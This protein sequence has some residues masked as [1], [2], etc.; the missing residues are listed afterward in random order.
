MNR[1]FVLAACA[2]FTMV[3]ATLFFSNDKLVLGAE[4]KA[5]SAAPDS[6]ADRDEEVPLDV[7]RDRAKVMHDVYE[8]TLEVM[9]HRYFHGN[10]ATVPARAMQDIFSA[11]ERQS[12]VKAR[13]ISVNMKPMSIDHEPETEFEKSAAKAIAK[14]KSHVD[15]V[16]NGFYRRA[17]AI[18]LSAGCVGC[19]G[20]LSSNPSTTPKFAALVISVPIRQDTPK[21]PAK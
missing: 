7:A 10:R 6:N 3:M 1:L 21:A 13:W 14:G 20:G 9:H 15:I 12:K 5:L 2:V 16:E 4:K 11:I 8:V 18:P 19:H 17:G